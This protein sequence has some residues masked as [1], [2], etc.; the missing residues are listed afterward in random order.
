M[1]DSNAKAIGHS[2]PGKLTSLFQFQGLL[3]SSTPHKPTLC[4]VSSFYGMSGVTSQ[5]VLSVLPASSQ[6]VFL[7]FPNGLLATMGFLQ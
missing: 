5:D 3:C 2:L 7:F 6:Y 1:V 4:P